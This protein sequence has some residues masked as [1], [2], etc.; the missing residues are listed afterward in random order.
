[1]TTWTAWGAALALALVPG[2]V[3]A[4]DAKAGE[5]ADAT[6]PASRQSAGQ[7]AF[8]D[9]FREMVETDTS[10]STGSCTALAQKIAARFRAAGFDEGQITLFR[11]ETLPLDGGIVVSL[12]GTSGKAKPMLLLG[13]LDVVNAKAQHW[14]SNPYVLT[15]R[16]GYFYGRGVADMKALDAIWIDT[17]LR[18]RAEGYK[19]K[20]TIKL[21]LTCGEETGG[22][23][24]GVEWLTR[25]RPELLAAEFAL[26]EGGGG[27]TDGRG[28]V[29]SQSIVIGE[30]ANRNF[31]L[32]AFSEGGH[33]S[34]P[35]DDNAIYKLADALV[36][37]RAI[38]FPV[39]FNDTTRSY[40][41]NIGS[42]RGDALGAAMVR[43]AANPADA[44]AE[45]TVSADRTMN[46][47]LRTTCVV[48]LVQ[49]GYLLNALPQTAKAS[50]NCRILPGE[51]A[52]TTRD[53]MYMAIG[54]PQMVLSPV[55]RVRPLAVPPPLSAKILQPAKKLIERYYPGV[56]LEPGI[57]TGATDATYLGPIGIPTYGVPGLYTDPDGNNVH[58]HDER[59]AVQSVC[60]ARD[61]LY[62]LVRAYAAQE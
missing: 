17:L 50:I 35:N 27:M 30:K 7:L 40:F 12:P 31:D 21:A 26:N 24:N 42:R 62:D 36:K 56:P 39:R 4:A 2:G 49:G 47:M 22:R 46:A 38:K 41:A 6:A 5:K 54:D 34:I 57:M 51:D 10:V 1:M 9:L 28:K 32:E 19:P 15:E 60:R 45:K 61:Y 25:H 52:E 43:L 55:G 29:L 18:L 8:R 13:H 11:D 53:T 37:V 33:S 59:I 44:D 20:R 23:M 48:T 14:K 3:L 16:D 58:G